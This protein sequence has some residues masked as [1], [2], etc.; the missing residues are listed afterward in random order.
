MSKRIRLNGLRQS[1]VGHT[2]IGL[3]RH[4]DS[5]AHEYRELAHW[6]EV[7]RI[8]ER[9][10][11]DTLFVADALGPLD[12]YQGKVDVALRDGVQTPTDDPLL[13]ISAMA[14][15][16]EHLGFAVTVSTT[17]EQPYGFARK[18]TTLDHL[19]KGRIGW[20]IVTSA[21]ESAARN[22]G[23]DRQIPHD[24]RYAQAEE[25]MEVVY[26]LWEGS[27]RDDAVVRS[28]EDGVFVDPSRV[29]P[30]RHE[31]EY[32]KVR[33]IAL[34]E[35]SVQ[36]TPVLFQAG[37]SRAGSA[38]AGR[39]AEG[40]FLSTYE[41]AGARRLVT[42]VKDAAR[43]AGRDPESL[44]FFPI[45][46]VVVAE[47]DAEARAKYADYASYAS[48]EGSLARWSALM[49]I[50]LSA[51]DPDK[52]LEY[53]DTDGIRGM[54]ELF[55]TLDPTRTWTPRAIGEFVGV[56]GGGPVLV[57]SPAT[58]ADEL[59]RW[60]DDAD[61]DGFN[62]ADPVAPAGHRDFVDLV[63]PELRRRGRVWSEYEGE[64]LRERFTGAAR[65]REDHPAH[66]HKWAE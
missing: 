12:T 26:K 25:F 6:T 31:G 7:A 59:E 46:T 24:E 57:G 28:V 3:W 13:P 16:T 62:I 5:R 14:A 63:V 30:V 58:V 52:P 40:V 23:L 55:T 42:Q 27:W 66:V 17:Y 1:T 18:M 37:T 9:G 64:T 49:Q 4:P 22:L 50:D 60:M 48:W 44:K 10:T 29:R 43:A 56:G 45:T 65:V 8:L 47:T 39:H 32:Y 41:T 11:F 15:V 33:D 34:S 21:L 38:F 51:L 36:R 35:P 19:T 54:V 20:N 53:V 2:A 61:V